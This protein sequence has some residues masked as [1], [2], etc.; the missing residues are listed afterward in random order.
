MISSSSINKNQQGATQLTYIADNSKNKSN[1]NKVNSN[2]SNNSAQNTFSYISSSHAD[3]ISFNAK[4][5]NKFTQT[6]NSISFN[7]VE[8]KNK[9]LVPSFAESKPINNNSLCFISEYKKPKFEICGAQSTSL[10]FIQNNK[11]KKTNF[12]I[13]HPTEQMSYISDGKKANNLKECSDQNFMYGKDYASGARFVQDNNY[14]K[15]Y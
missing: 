12:E 11:V 7:S 4:Q 14:N 9:N 10:E 13:G 3:N 2:N 5:N 15:R 6:S 8:N 1:N